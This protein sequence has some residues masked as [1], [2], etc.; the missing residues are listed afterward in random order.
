MSVPTPVNGMITDAV[1]QTS[2]GTLGN[3]PAMSMSTVYQSAAHSLSIMYENGVQAERQASISGQATANQGVIQIY[4]VPTMANA[5]ATAK[6][7]RSDTPD[8]MMALVDAL[9]AMQK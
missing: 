9:K 1:T 5:M 8:L 6:V 2:V 3:A 4:S 7:V